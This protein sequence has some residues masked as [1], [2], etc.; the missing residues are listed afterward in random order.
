MSEETD[1]RLL[2]EALMAICMTRDYV[3]ES[4]LPPI[5][6]WSWFDVGWKI[7]SKYPEL[8]SSKQ[9]VLRITK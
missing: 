7:A 8:D 4:L 9:F 1:I 2:D 6:G 5:K 3:G